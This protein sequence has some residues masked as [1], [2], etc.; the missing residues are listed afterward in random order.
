MD[1]EQLWKRRFLLFTLVRLTGVTVFLLGIAIA[2]SDLVRQGGWPEVGGIIAV[3]GA[4]DAV[5]A[6][7]V[8]K[9]YWAQEDEAAGRSSGDR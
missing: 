7:R 3:L 8:L 1:D 2:F 4:L 6:P 9:K 5:F